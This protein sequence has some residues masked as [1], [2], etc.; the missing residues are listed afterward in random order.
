MTSSVQ[1]YQ[2]LIDFLFLFIFSFKS[3]LVHDSLV[4]LHIGT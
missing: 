4:K 2:D 1:H 3:V